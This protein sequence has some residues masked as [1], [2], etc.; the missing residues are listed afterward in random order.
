LLIDELSFGLAPIAVQRLLPVVRAVADETGAAVL[1]VE[2]HVHLGLAIAERGYILS[3]GSIALSGSAAALQNDTTLL[4]ES[5]F[6]AENPERT[7][8]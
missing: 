8:A 1:L 6:G 2:Q 4:H 7:S 3:H 5:Y